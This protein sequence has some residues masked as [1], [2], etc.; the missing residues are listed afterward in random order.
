MVA[1]VADCWELETDWWQPK[2]V[3]RRYWALALAEGGLVTVF[4]D[5]LSGSWF[6]HG[7]QAGV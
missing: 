1:A 3:A 5:R 4:R 7:G 6:R 2:P